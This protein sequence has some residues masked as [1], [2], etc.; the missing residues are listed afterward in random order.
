[1]KKYLLFIG[2]IISMVIQASASKNDVY[3]TIYRKGHVEKNTTVHRS[4][5][6]LP[7]DVFYDNEAH[8]I[9]V[10]G[11]EE[12]AAKVFLC[13]ENGNTLDYSPCI[14]AVLYVPSN[15]KGLLIIRIEGEDWIATGK[16]L[17]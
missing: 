6:L 8:Q 1:M 10:A 11:D 3:M 13:D 5:M 14:N 2:V 17:V 12:L 4:P 9:E 7:I 15:H 16:I